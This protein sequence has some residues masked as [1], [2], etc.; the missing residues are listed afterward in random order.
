MQLKELCERFRVALHFSNMTNGPRG[1]FVCEVSVANTRVG[2][3]I[4]PRKALAKE[5]AAE[6]ALR[7]LAREPPRDL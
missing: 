2:R 4:G 5:N 7:A 1:G 3:G 6:N